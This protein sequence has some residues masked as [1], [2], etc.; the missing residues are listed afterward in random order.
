MK[1]I[2]F[3]NE[4]F[5]GGCISSLIV[6]LLFLRCWASKTRWWTFLTVLKTTR[7]LTWWNKFLKS[8]GFDRLNGF[9]MVAALKIVWKSGGKSF[10]SLWDGWL[11]EY[12]GKILTSELAGIF[13]SGSNFYSL[14][15]MNKGFWFCDNNFENK[16][17]RLFLQKQTS[18]IRG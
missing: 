10:K 2:E 4:R 11:L 15:K 1:I 3:I 16:F 17:S 18:S 7:S 9:D 6:H 8:H 14:C 13:L 5:F 12:D